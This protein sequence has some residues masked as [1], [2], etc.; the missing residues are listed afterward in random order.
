LKFEPN[1]GIEQKRAFFKDLQRGKMKPLYFPFTYIPES[2]G[3]VL[4]ALFGQT[5]VYQISATKVPD[6]MQKLVKEGLLDIRI[7]MGFNGELLDKI[8]KEYQVWISNHQGT[9]IAFLKTMAHKIP[10]FDDNTSSQIRAE[11]KK[12]SRQIPPKEK[13]HLLFNAGLFLH[14][15]QEYDRQNEKLSQDLMAIDAMEENVMKDLKGEETNDQARTRV[16]TAIERQ[17]SG[18]YMTAERIAAWASFM[19]NDPQDSELFITTSRAVVESIIDLAPETQEIIRFDTVS[20]GADEEDA[21]GN[22][23]NEFMKTLEVLATHPRP[24]TKD[25]MASPPEVPGS[26]I[27]VSLSLYVIPD[28]TPHECFAG[29]IETSMFRTDTARTDTRFK[30]TLI[31]V[32]EKR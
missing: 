14:M 15:A 2:V 10:F 30:N 25:N 3:K 29:C 8:Y 13:P 9:E 23:R 17:E 19:L 1:A 31:G 7:P 12:S 24:V 27:K 21:W 11:I 5:V 6:D 16:H 28:K 32:V 26:K 22:W 20:L 4:A 18:H